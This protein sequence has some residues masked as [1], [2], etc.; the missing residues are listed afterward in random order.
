MASVGREVAFELPAVLRLKVEVVSSGAPGKHGLPKCVVCRGYAQQQ[1]SVVEGDGLTG[2]DCTAC[3]AAPL[4]GAEAAQLLRGWRG[5]CRENGSPIG[6]SCNQT[7]AM[8]GAEGAKAATAQPC[9][10]VFP[11]GTVRE[12]RRRGSQR[13]NLGIRSDQLRIA[14]DQRIRGILRTDTIGTH[15]WKR[16]R[17]RRR[18]ACDRPTRHEHECHIRWQ[19][20]F[21]CGAFQHGMVMLQRYRRLAMPSCC[22]ISDTSLT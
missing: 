21:T 19:E 16:R 2:R 20:P 8:I 18:L 3:Q 7:A 1:A 17:D 11:N 15:L 5:R 9:S 12:S 10:L 13:R 22:L 14:A 6:I 4:P